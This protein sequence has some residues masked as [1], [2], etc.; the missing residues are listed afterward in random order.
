MAPSSATAYVAGLRSAVE[1]VARAKRLERPRI[2][3]RVNAHGELVVALLVAGSCEPT[4]LD[5][6]RAGLEVLASKTGDGARVAAKKSARAGQVLALVLPPRVEGQ[7]TSLDP[8]W[9]PTARLA[10]Y[11]I[12]TYCLSCHRTVRAPDYLALLI[13]GWVNESAHLD[14]KG[15]GW[16]CGAW[17]AAPPQTTN[18]KP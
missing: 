3:H 6:V 16:T 12:G 2:E 7:W 17:A 10:S 14:P 5:D 13:L 18:P 4:V 8:A 15:V 1:K 11:P 9:R